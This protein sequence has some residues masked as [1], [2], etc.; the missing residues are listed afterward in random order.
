MK[1][2]V[3][4]LAVIITLLLC[5]KTFIAITNINGTPSRVVVAFM[6]QRQGKYVG[7]VVYKRK[8]STT[9]DFIRLILE[10][11]HKL[12]NMN[13][14]KGKDYFSRISANCRDEVCS[15]FLTGSDMPHFNYCINKTWK[16]M[17]RN[18]SQSSCI[19]INGSHMYPVGLASYPGSGNTWVRGML[20]RVTGLCTGAIYCDITLRQGE[21]PGESIRSGVTFLVKSHQTDPRWEGILYDKQAPYTYFKKLQDVP[22]Y[23]GGIFIMRNPFHAMVAEFKRKT[24]EISR[25]NHVKTLGREYFGK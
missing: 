6:E 21:F 17:E 11:P 14:E 16:T 7:P 18:F 13:S 2:P 22:V 20:Q 4:I 5:H 10:N 19:F 3:T 9:K 15:E 23:S 12:E 1:K 8:E 25:E 24:W